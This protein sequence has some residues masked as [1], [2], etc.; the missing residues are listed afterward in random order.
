MSKGR[1]G[2]VGLAAKVSG[3]ALLGTIAGAIAY[4]RFG[5]PQALPR[6]PAL[7][8]TQRTVDRRAGP[9]AYSVA[10]SGPPVLLIHSINAAA[11]THEVGPIFE[12]LVRERRV[13]APDLPGFGFSDR[14]DRRYDPRLYVDAIHDMLDE[15]AAETGERHVDVLALSLSAE[16]L[17]RAAVERPD[18]FR[19]LALVTPTGFDRL[20]GSRRG[21]AGGTREVPVLYGALRVPLWSEGLYN[22]LV[23]KPSIRFFLEKTW[24]SKAIDEGAFRYSYLTS[25]QPGARFAPYA[26][27][28]GRLFSADIRSLYERLQ[29]PVI[30]LHGTKG[31]FQDFSEVGWTRERSNWRI[32]PFATG[33][34]PHFEDPHAFLERYRT[35]LEDPPGVGR[36]DQ[37]SSSSSSVEE[38]SPSP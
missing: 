22:L 20:S 34:L 7:S 38:R 25:H 29:L 33:A 21:Q 19:T 8:G 36:D 9:I 26:F 16:F 31:D 27:V 5:A 11:S 18:A 23:T 4:G 32:V 15:I 2:W 6:E 3:G 10:G 13:Y 1:R 12:A 24:G 37:T 17:A 30:V 28:S 14:S 35:F